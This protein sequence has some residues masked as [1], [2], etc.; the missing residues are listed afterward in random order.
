[1]I[2]NVRQVKRECDKMNERVKKRDRAM[3]EVQRQIANELIQVTEMEML[4]R[5]TGLDRQ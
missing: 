2:D 5:Q 1:M 4:I 3:D